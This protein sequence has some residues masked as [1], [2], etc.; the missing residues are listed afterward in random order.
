ME[1]SEDI[2]PKISGCEG[3]IQMVVLF[4]DFGERSVMRG[5]GRGEKLVYCSFGGY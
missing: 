4:L 5:G 2:F 1:W 3:G